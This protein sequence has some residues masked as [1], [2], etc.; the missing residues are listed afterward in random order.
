M[1]RHTG[2]CSGRRGVACTMPQGC[3]R[4]HGCEAGLHVPLAGPR[5]VVVTAQRRRGAWVGRAALLC[6]ERLQELDALRQR[7]QR[8]GHGRELQP[9]A[10]GIGGP[11][12]QG[13]GRRRLGGSKINAGGEP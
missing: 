11:W 10:G 3:A 12:V 13:C 9:E 8:G 4:R 1:W 6:L 7:V 2:L 5:A